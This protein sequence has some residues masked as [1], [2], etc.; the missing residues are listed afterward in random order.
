MARPL[1]LWTPKAAVRDVAEVVAIVVDVHRVPA[2]VT[3]VRKHSPRGRIGCPCDASPDGDSAPMYL[4]AIRKQRGVLASKPVRSWPPAL[5][6]SVSSMLS[7]S[8]PT[9]DCSYYIKG[10]RI[11]HRHGPNFAGFSNTGVVR[12]TPLLRASVN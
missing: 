10:R 8:S 9:C 6:T 7:P 11:E 2:T 3:T 12:G 5:R 1:R 4:D